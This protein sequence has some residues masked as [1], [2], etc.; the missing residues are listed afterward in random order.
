[1]S[2]RRILRLS[3]SLLLLIIGMGAGLR[4][5]GLDFGLPYAY[6]I[7]EPTYVS[8]ALNLGRGAIARQPNPTNFYNILFAEYALFYLIGRSLSWFGSLA[9]FEALY[10]GTPAT[11]LFLARI[12]SAVMGTLNIAVVYWLGKTTRNTLVGI[13]AA[14]FLAVSFLHV[15]DSHYGVP[16]VMMTLLVSSAVLLCI[17]AQRKHSLPILLGASFAAALA[18]ATKWSALPVVLPLALAIRAHLSTFESARVTKIT[19]V[20]M[21]GLAFIFGVT[22]G[23]P[24][25]FI[26]PEIYLAYMK[27]EYTSGEAGGFGIWQVDT[28]PG[29]VFYLQTLHTGMGT[30]VAILSVVGLIWIIVLAVRERNIRYD[31]IILLVFPITYFLLMGSTRHYFVRYALPLVPFCVVFAAWGIDFLRFLLIRWF[32]LDGFD[33]HLRAVVGVILVAAIL[34]PLICSLRFDYLLTQKDTR[35]LAKEWIEENIPSGSKI[36]TDWPVHGPPLYTTGDKPIVPIPAS[37]NVYRVTAIGGSGLSDH[38]AAYYREQ[39][40]EYLIASSFIYRLRLVNQEMEAARSAFYASL[41]A[42]YQLLKEFRPYQGDIAPPFAFDDIYGPWLSLF[43]IERP[44][45]VL[46]IYR[47]RS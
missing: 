17:V 39:G 36:A 30:I 45:P 3:V 8:A 47:V 23:F 33:W 46:K 12:T 42:E 32:R 6:H 40:Y 21:V 15:R 26:K 28:V 5:W 25:V 7:D 10:R 2:S 34:W 24:Q 44:G 13:G 11:F 41:D 31:V 37:R 27:S 35:T 22:V 29:W 16:D 19:I 1:M 20:A 43:W 4:V 18:F 14:S 9:D 38:N